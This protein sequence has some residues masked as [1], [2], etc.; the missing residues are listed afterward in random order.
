LERDKRAWIFD[1]L[2]ADYDDHMTVTGHVEG[3]QY[4]LGRI[5]SPIKGVRNVLDLCCGTGLSTGIIAKL[6]GGVEVLGLDISEQM[7][8]I[9]K[10][11]HKDNPSV[12]FQQMNIDRVCQDPPQ[13]AFNLITIVYGVCWFDIGSIIPTIRRLLSEDGYVVILDD[14]HLPQPIFSKRFPHVGG[15]IDE[16]RKVVEKEEITRLFLAGGFEEEEVLSVRIGE[17]H[18]SYAVRFRK[19]HDRS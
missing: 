16:V 8:S 12:R 15:V 1:S 5:L 17:T 3:E 13:N 11:K 9:A 19:I 7:L 2:A 10:K 6:V 14:L 4:L 18:T